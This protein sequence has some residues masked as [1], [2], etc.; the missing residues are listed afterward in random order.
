MYDMMQ[1][2]GTVADLS[3][4]L[5]S[6][7][8]QT[9][10]K[11]QE[12]DRL[13]DQLRKALS[14][15]GVLKQ[16]LAE[17][18]VQLLNKQH[19]S[20]KLQ[21]TQQEK[22]RLELDLKRTESKLQEVT[23]AHSDLEELVH[24]LTDKANAAEKHQ[25]ALEAHLRGLEGIQADMSKWKKM[26]ESYGKE[27]EVVRMRAGL[28]EEH[29]AVAERDR[30]VAEQKLEEL[31][32]T[33][34]PQLEQ[35]RTETDNM[36][37]QRNFFKK[38]ADSLSQDFE[39]LLR[40]RGQ[41][42]RNSVSGLS[43][44]EKERLENRITELEA[45]LKTTEAAVSAFKSA[46][47]QQLRKN[48]SKHSSLSFHDPASTPLPSSTSSRPSSSAS[49]SPPARLLSAS[50]TGAH[51]HAPANVSAQPAGPY[52]QLLKQ[53][54]ETHKLANVLSETISD[55]DEALKH[56][57]SSKQL[58]VKRVKELEARLRQVEPLAAVAQAQ[59]PGLFP[60]GE[61]LLVA[62]LFSSSPSDSPR[63]SS[64]DASAVAVG[65]LLAAVH[66]FSTSS[67]SSLSNTNN[68][69]FPTPNRS[70]F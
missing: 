62:S 21:I 14:L 6:A 13:Q 24:L 61:P 66:A 29:S 67:A 51:H 18:K 8:A 16:E 54:N 60:G 56:L 43:S 2:T 22:E 47:E 7:T 57:R 63:F 59:N 55:K 5:T 27:N 41:D 45:E 68:T 52:A 42:R 9:V 23:H 11:E 28:A 37:A 64:T 48:S 32:R 40:V 33:L 69:I 31:K 17:L 39:K 25:Q 58:L 34:V 46:F 44:E 4:Q 65:S 1:V 30:G 53:Y 50:L 35:A 38:K 3:D 70:S 36:T 49:S 15:E 12:L 10:A 26:A 20:S 19:V